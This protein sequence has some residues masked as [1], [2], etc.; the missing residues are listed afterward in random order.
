MRCVFESR[1]N[2][3]RS[4]KDFFWQGRRDSNTQPTVLETAALPVELHPYIGT[5]NGNRTRTSGLKGRR[6]KPFVH[7]SIWLRRLDSNQ[8]F[9]GSEPPALPLGYAS[10]YV[11]L[12]KP[13]LDLR[14]YYGFDLEWSMWCSV[15]GLNHRPRDYQ[16]RTLPS[17]LTEHVWKPRCLRIGSLCSCCALG[18]SFAVP[19]E[20]LGRLELPTGRLRDDC[21]SN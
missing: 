21:S 10:L 12:T 17:E 6:L 7:G 3:K 16:S 19:M 5:P 1:I 14:Q 20:L 8:R 15:V 2:K 18:P 4:P 11:I 9:G 13:F